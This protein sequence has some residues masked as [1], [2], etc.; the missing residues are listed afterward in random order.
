MPPTRAAAPLET[1]TLGNGG[2]IYTWLEVFPD[3]FQ[4][5][6]IAGRNAQAGDLVGNWGVAYGDSTTPNPVHNALEAVLAVINPSPSSY[7][8]AYELETATGFFYHGNGMYLAGSGLSPTGG[9]L[10]VGTINLPTG[11]Y[12]NDNW[13]PY[14]T[15]APTPGHIAGWATNVNPESGNTDTVLTDIAPGQLPGVAGNTAASAGNVGELQSVACPGTGSTAT[16]TNGSA[17]IGVSTTEPVGCPVWFSTTGT[18]PTNFSTS[19]TYYVVS[20]VANTSMQVTATIGGTAISA[21]SAGSG[22]Q[23]ANYQAYL[24]SGSANEFSVSA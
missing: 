12:V 4:S 22:T 23:T 9:D 5:R 24:T 19:T 3:V 11:H 13:L 7:Q 2:A 1:V 20:V 16:F 10:G 14:I 18:L 8:T 21:G 6:Y 15:T 17:T